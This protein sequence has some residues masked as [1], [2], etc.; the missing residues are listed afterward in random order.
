MWVYLCTHTNST[1]PLTHTHIHTER[2]SHSHLLAVN[3][4]ITNYMTLIVS[5]TS[6]FLQAAKGSIL[7][8]LTWLTT[9]WV[10]WL[11]LFDCLTDWHHWRTGRL[12]DTVTNWLTD[13]LAW[14]AS[15]CTH[16]LRRH[17]LPRKTDCC[18]NIFIA[19]LVCVPRALLTP[20]GGG[21]RGFFFFSLL[22]LLLLLL[23]NHLSSLVASL[24]CANAKL[25]LISYL[26]I[27]K[28]SQV[29]MSWWR[30]CHN[31]CMLWLS[32]SKRIRNAQIYTLRI[33]SGQEQ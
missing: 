2:E 27:A 22:S 6:V 5:F 28:A 9:G 30:E 23:R 24:K 13:W 7:P 18:L 29:V 26:T 3:V 31:L 1:H 33:R 17:S 32:M 20:D 16:Y 19:A 15:C 10:V 25:C 8:F 12:T 11:N 14:H 4:R 21:G